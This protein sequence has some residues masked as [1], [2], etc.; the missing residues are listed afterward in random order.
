[1]LN[2]NQIQANAYA[3]AKKWHTASNEEAD[4]QG[5]VTALLAVFGV[6]DPRAVGAFERRVALD[7]GHNGYFDYLWPG[8]IAIEMKSAGKDLAAAYRQ[9]ADYTLH[10]AP[11]DMPELL[12]VSDFRRI[13]LRHRTSGQCTRFNTANLPRYV[14]HF[15]RLAGYE[16]S[17]E[18]AEE[19]SVNVRA[20]EKIAR[21]HDALK[22]GGYD[23]HALEVY[24][25][26]LVFCFFVEDTE[27]FPAG[28]FQ[29]L[30]EN[31]QKDGADLAGR[32]AKLFEVLNI[33]AAELAKKTLLP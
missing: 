26:R 14:R 17:R 5:F 21:L 19:I 15:A 29:S 24:L 31:A 25:V 9:L 12:M 22:A 32:L 33:P 20:A 16:P 30:I 11:E 10:L 28:S 3:F 2:W 8:R 4:A 6:D 18:R 7:D 23:G 27:I 13:E 1:M